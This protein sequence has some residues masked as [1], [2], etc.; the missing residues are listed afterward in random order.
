MSESSKVEPVGAFVV[1]DKA[2]DADRRARL[3]ASGAG[4]ERRLF[5]EE[6]NKRTRGLL[7]DE[8]RTFIR[9]LPFEAIPAY[10]GLPPPRSHTHAAERAA[11]KDEDAAKKG[12]RQQAA[13]QLDAPAVAPVAD[14]SRTVG[15]T[16]G[17]EAIDQVKQRSSEYRYCVQELAGHLHGPYE[18]QRRHVAYSTFKDVLQAPDV[19]DIHKLDPDVEDKPLEDLIERVGNTTTAN[20][21]NG[22]LSDRRSSNVFGGFDFGEDAPAAAS[23]PVIPQH[24]AP[25]M[26]ADAYAEQMAALQR[27]DSKKRGDAKPRAGPI[28]MYDLRPRQQFLVHTYRPDR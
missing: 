16:S 24:A 27:N 26:T 17:H 2:D 6:A 4:P 20:T 3:N 10:K 5:L 8:L 7:E 23:A 11:Q 21:T 25:Q 28:S 14:E 18:T 1:T 15:A 9:D 19:P 13:T 12:K 22:S